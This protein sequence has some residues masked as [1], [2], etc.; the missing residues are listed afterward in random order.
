M[1]SYD[2][3]SHLGYEPLPEMT[4]M[5]LGGRHYQKLQKTMVARALPLKIDTCSRT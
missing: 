1:V 3:V 5:P 2:V 4:K